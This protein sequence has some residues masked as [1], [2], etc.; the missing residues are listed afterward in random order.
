MGCCVGGLFGPAIVG[1]G[2]VG[3]GGKSFG[4]GGKSFGSWPTHAAS[5][6]SISAMTLSRRIL[7]F[8]EVLRPIV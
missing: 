4:G 8:R 1:A 2:V 6:T 7:L 5:A 3:R